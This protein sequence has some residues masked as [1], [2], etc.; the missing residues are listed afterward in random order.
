MDAG[1]GETMAISAL[2][3][4]G[5]GGATSAATGQDPLKG[6]LI[7]GMGGAVTGGAMGA[8]GGA[9]TAATESGLAAASSEATQLGETAAQQA[10]DEALRNGASQTAADA[11]AQS[12]REY[13]S[14]AAGNATMGLNVANTGPASLTNPNGAFTTPLNS[15]ANAGTFGQGFMKGLSDNATPALVGGAG[16]LGLSAMNADKKKYGVPGTEHYNGP[17]NEFHYD[18]KTFKSTY[19]AQP[20]PAYTPQ[21]ANY[22]ADPYQPTMMAE[23]G[24]AQL[25]E[26]GDTSSHV[27]KPQYVDYRQQAATSAAPMQ[28]QAQRFVNPSIPTPSRSPMPNASSFNPMLIPHNP[29][30]QAEQ[31][32]LAAVEAAKTQALGGPIQEFANGGIAGLLK[33]RGDGMSDSIHATIADRQPARLADGEFVVPADVVSHLGNGSTDAGAKH[34]YS[35]MDKVRKARTGS[36]KQGKQIAAGGYLPA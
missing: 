20:N 29:M 26:G 24:I 3:G 32:R 19:P 18:P 31:D 28:P 13:A 33:G 34:L 22:A 25:A 7:G 9:G 14:N 8:F 21:Y 35:M 23:G 17:L 1:V 36:K 16:I 12:A 6:A 5:V 30:W 15:G 10:M 11:A 27:Y 4:A 2:I